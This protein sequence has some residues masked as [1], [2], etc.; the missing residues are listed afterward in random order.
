MEG[1]RLPEDLGGEFTGDSV[2]V[3]IRLYERWQII[4]QFL[5]KL[6]DR[7]RDIAVYYHID[8][9]S[10][11]DIA[12]TFG[13]SRPTV[14]KRLKAIDKRARRFGEAINGL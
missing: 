4:E 1:A 14:G 9:M 10:Q 8:G 5:H 7:D 2:P 6:S 3:E 11:A 13:W 12:R